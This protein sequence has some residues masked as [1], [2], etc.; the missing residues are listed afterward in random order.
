MLIAGQTNR[1]VDDDNVCFGMI[2][3][4]RSLPL[5]SICEDQHKPLSTYVWNRILTHMC[6]M[7]TINSSQN[8]IMVKYLIVRVK[9]AAATIERQTLRAARET[10]SL[11]FE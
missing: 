9:H 5:S 7:K 6:R 1:G 11:L 2:V 4:D 3:C 10:K 8:N